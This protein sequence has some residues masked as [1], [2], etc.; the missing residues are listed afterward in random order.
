MALPPAD[1]GHQCIVVAASL[2]PRMPGDR[3]KSNRRN[4]LQLARLLRPVN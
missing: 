2:I 4:A 1:Q 3:M